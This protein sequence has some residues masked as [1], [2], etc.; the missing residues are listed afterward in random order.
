MARISRRW[1]DS[2]SPPNFRAELDRG[3]HQRLDAEHAI[4]P[5]RYTSWPLSGR[6]ST[7]PDVQISWASSL[8]LWR[9]GS[10]GIWY[11]AIDPLDEPILPILAAGFMS[12][13]LND[14]TMCSAR[15]R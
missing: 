15:R 7:Y 11:V 8:K 6:N 4:S 3:R 1:N 12:L 10:D 9:R 5:V 14:G 2:G 13:E